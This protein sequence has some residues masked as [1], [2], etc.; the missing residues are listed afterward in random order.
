MFN[1]P[2]YRCPRCKKDLPTE[3][4][5]LLAYEGWVCPDGEKV[6]VWLGGW[7]LGTKSDCE[8]ANA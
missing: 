2:P 6:W 3:H 7:K 1:D 5:S 8:K 4:K